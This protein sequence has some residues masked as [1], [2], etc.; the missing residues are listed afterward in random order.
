MPQGN[1]M[2]IAFC[3]NNAHKDGGRKHVG[4][5]PSRECRS[6]YSTVRQQDIHSIALKYASSQLYLKEKFDY[7]LCVLPKCLKIA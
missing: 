2:K 1:R 4:F 3:R 7:F 5:S 6:E